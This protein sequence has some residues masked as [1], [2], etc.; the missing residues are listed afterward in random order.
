MD[1][2]ESK[3]SRVSKYGGDNASQLRLHL[4]PFFLSYGILAAMNDEKE[5]ID[6]AAKA[7]LAGIGRKGGAKTAARPDLSDIRKRGWKT[8]KLKAALT[9]KQK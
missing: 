8:R 7:Y 5:P 1:G 6:P 3:K 4:E 2:G 9:N